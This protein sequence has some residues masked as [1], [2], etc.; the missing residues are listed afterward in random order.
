M[1]L[2]LKQVTGTTIVRLVGIA[3]ATGGA[4]LLGHTDPF[5]STW[6]DALAPSATHVDW[7]LLAGLVCIVGG[8][9]LVQITWE[10]RNG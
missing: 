3:V 1:K 2:A 7:F 9:L 10:R 4:L 5:A 8:G 6:P